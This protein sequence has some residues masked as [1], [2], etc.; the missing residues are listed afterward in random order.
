MQ[1]YH[2]LSEAQMEP[3]TCVSSRV[4][5]TTRGYQDPAVNS[6]HLKGLETVNTKDS[7]RAT[8]RAKGET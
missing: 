5:P 8:K 7:L 3:G 6:Q 1:F 2:C 4:N